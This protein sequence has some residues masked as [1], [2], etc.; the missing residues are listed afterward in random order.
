MEHDRRDVVVHGDVAD[1]QDHDGVVAGGHFLLDRA[2]QPH[3]GAL[4]EHRTGI[5]RH[6]LQP[7]EPVTGLGRQGAR[8]RVV[9]LAEH[10]DAQDRQTLE[11]GPRLGG[12]LHAERHQRRVQRHRDE[13]AGGQTDPDAVD[14]GGDGDHPGREMTERL[15]QR[16]RG[17]TRLPMAVCYLHTYGAA[18]TGEQ[19]A[20][21]QSIRCPVE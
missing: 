12:V 13:R 6:R 9:R 15:A 21:F 16:R 5:R 7:G 2:L 18:H 8:G 1:A 20:E 4:D 19:L 11:P 10:A 3:A 17:S 14:F